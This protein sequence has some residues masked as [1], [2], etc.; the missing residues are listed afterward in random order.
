MGNAF[1]FTK[2]AQIEKPTNRP[3]SYMYACS[4][5]KGEFYFCGVKCGYDYCPRCGRPFE[6]ENDNG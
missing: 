6:K 1:I 2:V 4:A 5:C 3:K